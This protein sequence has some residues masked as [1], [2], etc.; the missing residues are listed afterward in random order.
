MLKSSGGPPSK[1]HLSFVGAVKRES[2][3]QNFVRPGPGATT[4]R[5]CYPLSVGSSSHVCS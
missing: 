4:V 3:Q 2:V 1:P 5:I